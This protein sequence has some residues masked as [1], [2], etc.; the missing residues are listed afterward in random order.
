LTVKLIVPMTSLSSARCEDGQ[1]G[2]LGHGVEV[3]EVSE[4]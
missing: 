2:E 3:Y 1:L 4:V